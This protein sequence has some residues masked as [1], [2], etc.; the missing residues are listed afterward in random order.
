MVVVVIDWIG[1]SNMWK[2]RLKL[3]AQIPDSGRYSL[4][5][6]HFF[7]YSGSIFKYQ[8]YVSMFVDFFGNPI[9][10]AQDVDILFEWFFRYQ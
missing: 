8:L 9:A 3:F 1:M 6:Y 5:L 4:K 10:L 7:G 2:W